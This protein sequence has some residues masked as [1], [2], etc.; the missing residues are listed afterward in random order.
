MRSIAA[1]LGDAFTRARAGASVADSQRTVAAASISFGR[2]DF[3]AVIVFTTLRI[4]LGGRI[5]T[6]P[7]PTLL[8][9]E[10]DPSYSRHISNAARQRTLQR[11]P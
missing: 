4:G 10:C 8:R 11:F 6:M 1:A 3:F 7:A 9:A 2:A 5:F